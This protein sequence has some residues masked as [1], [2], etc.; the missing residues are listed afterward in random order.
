MEFGSAFTGGTDQNEGEV[1]IQCHRYH[2][3]FS[4]AL[5]A[6]DPYTL[7]VYRFVG[8]KIVEAARGSPRP[9]T[10]RAP[11]VGFAG[12]T[13]VGKTD[14]AFPQTCPIVCLDATR[15]ERNVTP[16]VGNELLRRRRIGAGTASGS[17]SLRK[18]TAAEHHH[19]R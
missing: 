9:S 19:D 8:F 14:D 18:A 10:Q 7:R 11:V 3:R 4:E 1:P 15:I 5:N 16:A 12:L 2:G 13:F 6:F 17:G